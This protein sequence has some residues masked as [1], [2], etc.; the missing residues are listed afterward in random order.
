[1]KYQEK[2]FYKNRRISSEST[3]PFTHLGLLR[4]LFDKSENTEPDA[5]V[6]SEGRSRSSSSRYRKELAHIM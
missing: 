1:M 6:S 3:R 2:S 4:T 5:V